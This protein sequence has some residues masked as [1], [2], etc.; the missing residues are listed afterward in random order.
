MNLIY[1]MSTRLIDVQ[2]K[3]GRL[4]LVFEFVDSDLKKYMDAVNGPLRPELIHVRRFHTLFVAL[5]IDVL[6]L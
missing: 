4:Y 6:P 3:D 2:N 5:L 1:I